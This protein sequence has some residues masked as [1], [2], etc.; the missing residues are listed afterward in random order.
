ML[1]LFNKYPKS[2]IVVS[3]IAFI[4]RCKKVGLNLNKHRS[5]LRFHYTYSLYNSFF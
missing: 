4:K 1:K 3:F 5:H 2:L